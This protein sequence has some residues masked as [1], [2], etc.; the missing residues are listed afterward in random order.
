[1]INRKIYIDIEILSE[2]YREFIKENNIAD[3]IEEYYKEM[4]T[5]YSKFIN[6]DDKIS[7]KKISK[8]I[9]IYKKALFLDYL[10]K[11]KIEEFYSPVIV[12]FRG[13]VYITS[14]LSLTFVKELRYCVYLGKYDKKFINNYKTTKTDE[15]IEKKFELLEKM[16]EW[17][18]IKKL[19]KA[20]KISLIWTLISIGETMIAKNKENI[21]MTEFIEKGITEYEKIGL[22]E[23]HKIK[24]E[25]RIKMILFKKIINMLINSKDIYKY[26]ISKDATASV[27]Q[28]LVKLIGGKDDTSY[29]AVNLMSNDTWY[30]PYLYIINNWKNTDKYKNY[31]KELEA[32]TNKNISEIFNRS[33]LKKTLMTEN[34]GCGSIKCWKY[35]K[36]DME[37]NTE[38]SEIIGDIE[39]EKIIKK[40]FNDFYMS[41][42]K[43]RKLTK[44]NTDIITKYL[45]K[46]NYQNI[47]TSDGLSVDLRYHMTKKERID[48]KTNKTRRTKIILT[49]T[50]EIDWE[51]TKISGKANYI[52][53]H[54]STLAR[55]VAWKIPCIII[56]DCFM[57]GCLEVSELIEII[58][59]SFKLKFEK[60]WPNYSKEISALYSIF[61][62]I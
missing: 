13:R 17:E 32:T 30:D 62:V 5:A 16:K 56:H 58:N 40:M 55:D 29:T 57:V 31:I 46:K 20:I 36:E 8:K 18:K 43:D 4:L 15:L 45:E 7:I 33:S 37:E 2:I 24:Y 9:S 50:E 48:T 38:T 25:K 27:Y 39:T 52:H 3:N 21:K 60:D 22:E 19:K 41:I 14:Q 35:F 51:K 26:L 47:I 6:E 44:E 61:I 59:T 12:D 28:H 42:T 34:Y 53:L 11:N 23:H 1:M 54:D 10:V 49:K